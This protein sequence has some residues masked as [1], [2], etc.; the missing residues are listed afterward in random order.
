M[1]SRSSHVAL[2]PD[3]DQIRR[4]TGCEYVGGGGSGGAR[5]RPVVSGQAQEEVQCSVGDHQNVA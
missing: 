4:E 1:G 5:R 2:I 3:V